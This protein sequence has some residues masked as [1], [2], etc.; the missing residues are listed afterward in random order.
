MPHATQFTILRVV[1]QAVF[2]AAALTALWVTAAAIA[3]KAEYIATLYK[4]TLPGWMSGPVFF[5]GWMT[6]FNVFLILSIAASIT[7]LFSKNLRQIAS[8]TLAFCGLATALCALYALVASG[9][10]LTVSFSNA[11]TKEASYK[12]TL[13]EFA[14]L[15]AAEG[16]FEKLRDSVESARSMR[17]VEVGNITELSKEDQQT[18][19]MALMSLLRGDASPATKKMALASTIQF[20]EQ[21]QRSRLLYAEPVLKAASE[22][23]VPQT[24]D[25]QSFYAWLEP[26]MGKDGWNPAPMFRI[27]IS[28]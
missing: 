26:M 18:R 24:A 10:A 14:I 13:E 28:R 23:G 3:P 21:I 19:L 6:V 20:R 8:A 9:A 7:A 1:G 4:T 15:Q 27:E 17:F 16:R 25:V 22:L 5:S 11:M 12:K 2:A